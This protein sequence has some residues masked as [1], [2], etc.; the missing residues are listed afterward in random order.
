MV[1]PV[2]ADT[3]GV[4]MFLEDAG[5]PGLADRHAASS[6]KVP[7]EMIRNLATPLVRM[8]GLEADGFV[9]DPL[10][11]SGAPGTAGPSMHRSHVRPA[12]ATQIAGIEL[13]KPQPQTQQDGGGKN[14]RHGVRLSS[15]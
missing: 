6:G 10:R 15:C 4:F 8:H 9:D 12:P 14:I 3:N 1:D 13:P 2:A 7:I 5:D 11:L